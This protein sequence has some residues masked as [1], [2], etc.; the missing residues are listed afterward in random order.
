LPNNSVVRIDEDTTRAIWI[1]TNPG[2]A[3]WKDGRLTRVAPEP[4]SPFDAYLTAPKNLGVDGRFFG[5][6]RM[7]STGWSR[8]AYG[9]W[10]TLPLPPHL[11]YLKD[12][13][14]LRVDSILSR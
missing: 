6:W 3:Q 11:P 9:Q 4:G 8:F 1:T 13:E 7:D 5:L 2:L 14:R 12:P 10:T